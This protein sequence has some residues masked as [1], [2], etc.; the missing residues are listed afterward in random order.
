M[1]YYLSWS[2][3]WYQSRCLEQRNESIRFRSPAEINILLWVC[4][5]KTVVVYAWLLLKSTKHTLIETILYNLLS[6][7]SK[8][9]KKV[10]MEAKEKKYRPNLPL[11]LFSH[12]TQLLGCLYLSR[13]KAAQ[14]IIHLPVPFSI[15][16][17]LAG[18]FC[19][20]LKHKIPSVRN[21]GTHSLL[22]SF[23][24]LLSFRRKTAPQ[25]S[26]RGWWCRKT[27]ETDRVWG[28][29]R[30]GDAS[31]VEQVLA[32]GE[33]RWAKEGYKMWR[34]K[35]VEKKGKRSGGGFMLFLHPAYW[36]GGPRR[37]SRLIGSFGLEKWISPMKKNLFPSKPNDKW[38]IDLLFTI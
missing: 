33:K 4:L 38:A 35:W 7:D 30:H 21:S 28:K 12:G 27:A 26:G 17:T 15:S 9:E 1:N 18:T 14:G 20:P 19:P 5:N 25:E 6:F 32:G 11:N 37:D 23:L 13:D 34:K 2:L 10:K 24:L 22:R 36:R 31:E 8:V 16:S 3:C 29:N